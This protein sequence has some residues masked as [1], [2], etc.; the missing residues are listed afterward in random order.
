MNKTS[1]DLIKKVSTKLKRIVDYTS[2]DDAAKIEENEK[3]INLVE[4]ILELNNKIQS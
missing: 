1:A 2:K 3:M 4:R